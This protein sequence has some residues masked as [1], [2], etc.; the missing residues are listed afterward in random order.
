MIPTRSTPLQAVFQGST[1]LKLGKLRPMAH[2]TLG[3]NYS[4]VHEEFS[5]AVSIS[6][7]KYPE[8]GEQRFPKFQHQFVYE[9]SNGRAARLKRLTFT[10]VLHYVAYIDSIGSSTRFAPQIDFG[11]LKCH[12]IAPLSRHAPYGE[13][14]QDSRAA[15]SNR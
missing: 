12:Q 5:F 4:D 1:F 11:F 8:H 6:C 9:I 10:S 14:V 7:P 15:D 2:A 3:T 13:V